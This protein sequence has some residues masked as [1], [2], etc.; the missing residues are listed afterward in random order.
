MAEE[1]VA[2]EEALADEAADFL[3][4]KGEE[5]QDDY[6]PAP[7][8]VVEGDD[9]EVEVE[10]TEEVTDEE[11]TGF[12]EVE[13]EGNL[14]EVPENLKDA[15]L[16][17]SDYTTKTQEVAA[18]RK[19]VEVQLGAI[20]QAHDQFQFAES[21]QGDVIK[22]QQLDETAKQWHE[23]L[24][25]NID[26]LS[27]TDIEKIRLTI[28]DSRR[29]RDEIAQSVQSKQSEFQ[30]A[31]EQ[32]HAELLNKGTEVLRQKIPGW[33]EQE[34]KQVRDY[35]LSIGFTEADIGQVVDPRQVEVLY[36]AAQFDALKSGVTPAVKKVQ[37][38]PSIKPKA[39]NPMPDDVKSKL[40]LRKKLKS[41]KLTNS[42]KASLI[43]QDIASKFF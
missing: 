3:F 8:P 43:G 36:K 11:S 2:P 5:N 17:Q 1:Q 16:R 34:Q 20:K 12:V 35:A 7:E 38:A 27:S 13:F 30:Q 42:D 29:E 26:Q 15:L 22:A 10:A 39:R 23:Y 14:Y 40:N 6:E 37:A 21:I 18:Q 24:R 25:N 33:G 4:G 28:E 9:E 41:N 32:S 31:Q 19:E